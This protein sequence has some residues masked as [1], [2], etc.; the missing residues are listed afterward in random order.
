VDD[1]NGVM[2]GGGY[3]PGRPENG[4]PLEGT[5]SRLP[6]GAGPPQ[7]TGRE[8]VDTGDCIAEPKRLGLPVAVEKV[9]E[10]GVVASLGW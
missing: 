1:D 8:T 10:V 7:E 3:W 2:K 4:L 5:D 6:F 9:A